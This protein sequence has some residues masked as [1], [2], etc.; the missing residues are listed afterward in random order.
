MA[1]RVTT[2]AEP[3]CGSN[4]TFCIDLQFVRHA[5][6]GGEHV[7][8]GGEDSAGFQRRDQRRLVD[9]RA[10]RDVD[11]DAARAER[12][13]H[14]GIDHLRGGGAAG[15]DHDQRI[16]VLRHL[17]Q[18]RIMLVGDGR[19]LV[20]RM[21]EDRHQRGLEP[22]ADRLADAAHADDADLAVAQRA[23]AQRIVLGLPQAGA[24]I[25]IG[26]DE[27]AQR[28][29]QQSHRDVGDFLGQHVRRVGDD[30]VMLARIGEIDMVIADA[31]AGDD[32]EL[33]EMRQRL[34]VR[35][36]RVVG[37]GDAADLRRPLGR[38]PFE[39][40]AGFRLVQDKLVR[41]AVFE[42]RPDRPVDQKIDLFGRISS[43][44]PSIFLS[45]RA[46]MPAP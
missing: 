42:D 1:L 34:L 46:L 36:H 45:K 17:H 32:F 33:R 20:A 39:V 5:G 24:H 6:L 40:G 11:D 28:R 4:T 7:E 12:L 25:A 23:D 18:V 41:E 26:L 37:H 15:H 14:V 19:R 10:A 2:E 38:Q 21:V 35:L 3:I 13:Q 22:A 8:A 29:D 16:D 44:Q 43:R 27:F 31:E 30:D 9:H